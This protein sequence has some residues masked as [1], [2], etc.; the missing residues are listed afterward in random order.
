MEWD[1]NRADFAK[2]AIEQRVRIPNFVNSEKEVIPDIDVRLRRKAS[3]KSIGPHPETILNPEKPFDVV[4]FRSEGN[5]L[6][7][8]STEFDLSFAY[9]KFIKL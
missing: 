2:Y 4:S 6:A 7:I 3:F 8:R 9:L 5:P 1:E